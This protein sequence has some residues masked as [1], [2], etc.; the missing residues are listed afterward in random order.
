[1]RQCFRNY[2]KLL[3]HISRNVFCARYHI[4]VSRVYETEVKDFH[5][6]YY[7]ARDTA[8]LFIRVRASI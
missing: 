3:E 7:P 1:M 2:F 5:T 6:K 4:A 8:F